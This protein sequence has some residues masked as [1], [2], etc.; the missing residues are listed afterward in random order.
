MV[1]CVVVYGVELIL[2]YEGGEG[3]VDVVEEGFV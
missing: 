1:Y 3:V 2:C